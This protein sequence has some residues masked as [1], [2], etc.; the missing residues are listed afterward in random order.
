MAGSGG[1]ARGPV[2]RARMPAAR[3]RNSCM[4]APQNNSPRE[5]PR[6]GACRLRIRTKPNRQVLVPGRATKWLGA[7]PNRQILARAPHHHHN[8]ASPTKWR[9]AVR[10]QSPWDPA[11]QPPSGPC[12]A[13]GREHSHQEPDRHRVPKLG[14]G[15]PGKPARKLEAPCCF[16]RWL[17]ELPQHLLLLLIL[18][19]QRSLQKQRAQPVC[20]SDARPARC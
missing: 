5:H 6:C 9:V 17:P 14:R 11:K 13:H 8:P 15:R 1:S 16:F 2:S 20:A 18:L 4:P 19:Q 7:K 3:C 10:G 12:T